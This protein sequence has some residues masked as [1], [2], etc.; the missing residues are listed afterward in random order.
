MSRRKLP[1]AA[2]IEETCH[3][4]I[5]LGKRHF[6]VVWTAKFSVSKFGGFYVQIVLGL[7]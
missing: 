1:F 4:P 7:G 6:K 2:A 5:D 3:P